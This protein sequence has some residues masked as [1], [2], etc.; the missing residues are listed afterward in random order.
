MLNWMTMAK[1]RVSFSKLVSSTAASA[2]VSVSEQAIAEV[3]V[4]LSHENCSANWTPVPY[5]SCTLEAKE[6]QVGL[7]MPPDMRDIL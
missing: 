3:S 2:A 5:A 6:S 1:K 7:S 4:K